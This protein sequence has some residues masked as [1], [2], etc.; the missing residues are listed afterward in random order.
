MRKG[1]EECISQKNSII[2]SNPSFSKK[3]ILK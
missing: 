2:F 1:G 3:V